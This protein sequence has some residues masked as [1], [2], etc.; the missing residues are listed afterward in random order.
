MF[1]VRTIKNKFIYWLL[2]FCFVVPTHSTEFFN[3][4]NTFI[5]FAKDKRFLIGAG[6][7]ST[8]AIAA[9]ILWYYNNKKNRPKGRAYNAPARRKVGQTTSAGSTTVNNHNINSIQSTTNNE[10]VEQPPSRV[11]V[12]T[13]NLTY[14]KNQK[15]L[16]ENKKEA[17]EKHASEKELDKRNLE[18]EKPKVEKS[19]K[20]HEDG[21]EDKRSDHDD[22]TFKTQEDLLEDEEKFLDENKKDAQENHASEKKLDKSNLEG[23]KPKVEQGHYTYESEYES[24]DESYSQDDETPKTQQKEF[25]D[26]AQ[27]KLNAEE[28]KDVEQNEDE[29]SDDDEDEKP[30]T[31]EEELL[32][33]KNK[34][35]SIFENAKKLLLKIETAII[36]YNED[37][38]PKILN[39]SSN[40]ITKLQSHNPVYFPNNNH[41]EIF[42]Q[43]SE[44]FKSASCLVPKKCIPLIHE[45]VEYKKSYGSEIE[46]ELYKKISRSD[47]CTSLADRLLNKRPFFYYKTQ[48]LHCLLIDIDNKNIEKIEYLKNKEATDFFAKLPN[49]P[50]NIQNY[51]TDDEVQISSLFA[52]FSTCAI[53]CNT[54]SRGNGGIVSCKNDYYNKPVFLVA[55]VGAC[56]EHP[57][58]LQWPFMVISKNQNTKEN[59]YGKI[60]AFDSSELT[61]NKLIFWAKFYGLKNNFPTFQE[62]TD[63]LKMKN[64]SIT[65]K[66]YVDEEEMESQ[67][68]IFAS[69]NIIIDDKTIFSE[70]D[71]IPFFNFNASKY[72]IFNIAVYKAHMQFIINNFLDEAIKND[73]NIIYCCGLGTGVWGTIEED[74]CQYKANYKNDPNVSIDTSIILGC[75]QI[76]IYTEY[77]K[78][79]NGNIQIILGN[80]GYHSSSEQFDK[81]LTKLKAHSSLSAEHLVEESKDKLFMTF[82]INKSSLV[83]GKRE[84]FEKVNG[85]LAAMFAWDYRGVVGN[86][87]FAGYH[88]QS[89]D[90]A[91][92]AAVVYGYC[93]L[94][95]VFN[96]FIKQNI[97]YK[98][99]AIENGE[100]VW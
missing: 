59:G 79:L 35:V 41:D 17:E 48:D 36:E 28:L 69:D 25:L 84:P 22:G 64:K 50:K 86:E 18:G 34:A 71:Y 52:L 66:N 20:K 37:L 54:G 81:N 90:P 45:F 60:E 5:P 7:A 62:A 68:N 82:N 83:I 15:L 38:W 47:I 91:A 88:S 89:G 13:E 24:E 16:D 4:N 100:T 8:V 31:Q 95:H 98:V 74:K 3:F 9:I 80:F 10:L 30:K 46:K 39:D 56:F 11:D 57:G 94:N 85:N 61:A 58:L 19:E 75:I 77:L 87:G 99:K 12:Q 63:A 76:D 73:K 96:P 1:F 2:I 78:K 6:V 67:Q 92:A 21:L 42:G 97:A 93:Q 70:F 43:I 27:E 29:I 44:S 55:L 72:I 49:D 23:K 65:V 33:E 51:C 40:M 26:E 32:D 53:P 14:Q